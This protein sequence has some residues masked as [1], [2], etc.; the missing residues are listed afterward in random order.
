MLQRSKDIFRDFIEKN[1]WGKE[2]FGQR[3][4]ELLLSLILNFFP[5]RWNFPAVAANSREPEL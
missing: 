1:V 5:R 2:E 3:R 4:S